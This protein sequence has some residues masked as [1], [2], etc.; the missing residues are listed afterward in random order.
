[1]ESQNKILTVPNLLTILRMLLIPVIV[2][3]YIFRKEYVWALVVVIFSGLTDLADGKI[4][5]KYNLISN[6]GKV[7]D[8]VADKLT[9]VATLFCLVTRFPLMWLPLV[10][11][12]VK[13]IINGILCYNAIRKSGI[14]LCS[15]WHGKVATTLLYVTV[16]AH[17][18]WVNI[19]PVASQI[20]IYATSA[21]ML[22][23]GVMYVIRNTQQARGDFNKK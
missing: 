13:E 20:L 2:W 21:I 4:A 11:L 5:R 9:Q 1:M 12:A 8:P 15:D 17:M 10:L 19:L 22:Y 18:L 7:M 6:F 16:A 23:S 14:V 3:L